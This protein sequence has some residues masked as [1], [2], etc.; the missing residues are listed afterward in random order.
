MGISAS[1]QQSMFLKDVLKYLRDMELSGGSPES[2]GRMY[3]WISDMAKG[4]STG[5]KRLHVTNYYATAATSAGSLIP[6]RQMTA[7]SP[8]RTASR[9]TLITSIAKEG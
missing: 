6:I 4:R 3:R 2:C 5:G 9:L 7:P 1:E 8:V